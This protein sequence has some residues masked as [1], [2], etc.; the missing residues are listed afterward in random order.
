MSDADSFFDTSVLL[1]LLYA[2]SSRTD[3]IEELLAERGTISVRISN[4]FAAVALRNLP[5]SDVRQAQRLAGH[6][7]I[8]K[9]WG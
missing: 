9:N 3:R 5:L 2:D 4:K 8:C 7:C 1:C 6:S